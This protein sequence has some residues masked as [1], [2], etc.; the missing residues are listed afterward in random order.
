MDR[1]MFIPGL[2]IFAVPADSPGEGI[3]WFQ[4]E[5]AVS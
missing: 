1:S 3:D 5:R 4:A 2:Q